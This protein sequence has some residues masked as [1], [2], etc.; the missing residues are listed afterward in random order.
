MVIKCLAAILPPRVDL[1]QLMT[2]LV[3]LVAVVCSHS[4]KPCEELVVP[5]ELGSEG[6]CCRHSS[7]LC[8]RSP[9]GHCSGKSGVSLY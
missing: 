1:K 4:D 3:L 6:G 8:T 9:V 7:K 2:D 5:P